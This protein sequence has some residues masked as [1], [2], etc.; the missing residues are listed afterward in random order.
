MG[1]KDVI[2]T[3]YGITTLLFGCTGQSR[4]DY[5]LSSAGSNRS[6]LETV[7]E[8][9]RTVDT[10]PQKLRAAEF[11]IEN[12]PAHYSYAGTGIYEYYDYAACILADTTL[13]PEQ[14]RD[15]LLAATNDRYAN[16][17][18][19]TV[20]DAQIIKADFLL[21]NI[22]KS[23]AQWT[24][25]PWAS[26]VTF[27]EYLEW[28]LPYKAVELQELDAWRDTLKTRF[29]HGI[30]HMIPNDV[31]YNTTIKVA[32]IIRNE[33]LG[34]INRYGLYER[35]GLPVLSSDL[36]PEQT[37]G[38]IGDYA[39]LA[40]LTFRSMGIPAVLDETP[41]GPRHTAASRWFV[42][43]SDRGCETPSEWDISTVP[44]WGFFP[45]ER[46][47]KV[48][49]H[50]YSINQERWK[51]FCESEYS[52]PFELGM[53]DVTS[54]Y[55]LTSDVVIQLNHEGLERIDEEYAYIASAVRDSVATWQIVDFCRI[56]HGKA[57]FHDMGREVMYI[58][59][60]YD[61]DML[62]EITDPFILLKDG[63]VKYLTVSEAAG[64]T[65]DSFKNN[66]K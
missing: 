57:R 32:D 3:F 24:T 35:A 34:K 15:S 9:Y 63:S 19:H 59:M 60:G 36:L 43:L 51:Y 29:C 42:L 37:F 21:D 56:S 52:Y 30:L 18:N 31:E 50:T 1:A 5:A 27:D 61:G 49:R 8:H 17:P 65:Y 7:L 41:V 33:M 45:Y 26:Q 48:Y 14:Q 16:L 64:D 44:G 46:G 62:F 28:M 58:V 22:D 13:T 4:L 39:L 12:L 66:P 25:C 2:A 23:Y 6:E 11:L 54:K 20:P 55:F 47:P 40:M 38:N 53:M 10:N